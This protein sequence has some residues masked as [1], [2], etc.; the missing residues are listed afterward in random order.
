MV[1]RRN[2]KLNLKYLELGVPVMTQQK[3]I[4]LG[5]MRLW[6]RSLA[7]PGGLRI[8]HCCELWRRSQMWLRSGI[9]VTVAV[10]S[11]NSSDRT[12]SLGTSICLWCS[13]KRTKDKRKISW[14]KWKWSTVYRIST[15]I[16]QCKAVLRE[17]C[18]GLNHI[19]KEGSSSKIF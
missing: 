16:G 6:V 1:Q 11:S 18:I 15:F 7:L 19:W 10:A 4:Q 14:T 17:K 13:P 12:P 9:T 8:W 5:T 3:W 2:Y